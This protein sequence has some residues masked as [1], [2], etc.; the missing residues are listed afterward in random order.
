MPAELIPAGIEQHRKVA[1]SSQVAVLEP[2]VQGTTGSSQKRSRTSLETSIPSKRIYRTRTK[3]R[4]VQVQ[5]WT[6]KGLSDVVLQDDDSVYCSLRWEDTKV[7]EAES[8]DEVLRLQLEEQFKNTY[9]VK[10]WK[11]W[12]GASSVRCRRYKR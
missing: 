12:I 7:H 10:E 11:R 9:G 4:P 3:H 2:G 1:E 6:V 5:G 8:E